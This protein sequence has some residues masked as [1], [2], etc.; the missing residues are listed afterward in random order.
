MKDIF[1]KVLKKINKK[2]LYEDIE[3]LWKLELPQTSSAHVASAAYA[4]ELLNKAGIENAEIINFPAD[5]KT[6]YQDKRMPWPGTLQW[7][8]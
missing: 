5:G 4:L 2:Q 7:D 6:V 1:S 8:D 3:N